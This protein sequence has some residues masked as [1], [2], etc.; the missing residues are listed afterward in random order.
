M[1]HVFWLIPNRLAGRP[2]PDVAPW[3]LHALRANGIDAILSVNDGLLCHPSAMWEAGLEYSCSPLSSNLPPRP[4]D[5][6]QCIS[7]LHKAMAFVETQFEQQRRV[8]VY[9]SMG[10]ERTGLF[11]AYYLA[12]T[13]SLSPEAAIQRVR[14]VR[15]D[16]LSAEGWQA[17]AL[18]VMHRL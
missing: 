3:D 15:P 14:A 10:Q 11:L 5:E 2:G 12:A 1:Q 16:A 4:G 9:C 8:L 17:L 7:G 13:E 6:D 18:R